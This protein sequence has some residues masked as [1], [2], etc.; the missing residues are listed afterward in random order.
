MSD[1]IRCFIGIQLSEITK[2]KIDKV[3]NI[4]RDCSL[5][6]KWVEKYN[7]HITIK[8]L[9]ELTKPE[10]EEVGQV[11]E[12]IA[13][14]NKKPFTIN[15]EGLGAFPNLNYPRTMWV[16]IEKGSQKLGQI[17]QEIENELISLGFKKKHHEYT[18]HITLGRVNPKENNLQLLSK[19]L[20]EFPFKIEIPEVVDKIT[21]IKSTLTPKGPI[22]QSLSE[23]DLE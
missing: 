14:N 2:E 17:N 6:V 22:Y 3:K 4:L 11:L 1:K 8:F 15:I 20:K 7:F 5:Q 23:F 12:K 10:I 16:G 18:P 19:K 9:G 13:Q 21:L